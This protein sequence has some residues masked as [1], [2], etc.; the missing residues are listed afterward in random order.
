MRSRQKP[1][2]SVLTPSFTPSFNCE[3]FCWHIFAP[4]TKDNMPRSSFCLY[5]PASLLGPSIL[6]TPCLLSAASEQPLPAKPS[7]ENLSTTQDELIK[8]LKPQVSLRLNSGSA[9]QFSTCRI[10]HQITLPYKRSKLSLQPSSIRS[11]YIQPPRPRRIYR[12]PF[13]SPSQ[14]EGRPS[15]LYNPICE[16]QYTHTS[17]I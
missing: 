2:H 10:L 15:T 11:H 17:N 7:T 4:S 16:G 9:I 5:A 12:S 1:T 8:R 14:R 3:V 13:P 6:F